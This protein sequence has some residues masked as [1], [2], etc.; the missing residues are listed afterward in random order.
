MASRLLDR[1]TSL[2]EYLTSSGAIF[3]ERRDASADP[4]RLGIDDRLLRLEARFSHE[5]RMEKIIG[6]F[7]RTFEILGDSQDAIVREFVDA[8]PSSDISRFENARQFHDFLSARWRR[9]P[10]QPPHL[11]DVAACELACAKVRA[12][13]EGQ[14][15][16]TEKKAKEPR[17]GIRRPPGLVLLRC[18]Y[19]IRNIFEGDL[20]AGTPTNRDTLLAVYLPPG[21]DQP[22]IFELLAVVFNLLTALND[23]TDPAVFREIPEFEEVLADLCENRL[24]E[25]HS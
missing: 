8:C 9:K 5:K 17:R 21:T 15:S 24:L 25:V 19:D 6:V 2:L 3:G 10:P 12:N 7:S 11:P 13:A 23:W 20:R 16:E 14:L 4:V 1:Q 22:R 18:S